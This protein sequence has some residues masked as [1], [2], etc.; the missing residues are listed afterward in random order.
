MKGYCSRGRAGLC[1]VAGGLL[2]LGS[3]AAGPP[4]GQRSIVTTSRAV[5]SH[6]S[7]INTPAECTRHHAGSRGRTTNEFALNRV[8]LDLPA[9]PRRYR[10]VRA[11]R[12]PRRPTAEQA[13]RAL[14]RSSKLHQP[15]HALLRSLLIGTRP[16]MAPG[17]AP[18]LETW[19]R[20]ASATTCA[21]TAC[22]EPDRP[23]HRHRGAARGSRPPHGLHGGPQ[24]ASLSTRT[25]CPLAAAYVAGWSSG[26]TGCA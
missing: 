7:Q 25:R 3:N 18:Q 11:F 4:A 8:Y 21:T 15:L 1:T 14:L 2:V 22:P 26:E 23:Y 20:T 19:R 10:G 16:Q 17:F 24:R 12:R 13:E 6:R 5:P 9:A